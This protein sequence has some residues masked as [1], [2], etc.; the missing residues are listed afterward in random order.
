MYNNDIFD[1]F[2]GTEDMNELCK[3]AI[4]RNKIEFLNFVVN[5]ALIDS[6]D[7]YKTIIYE[8]AN[9]ELYKLLEEVGNFD[10]LDM[11]S[12]NGRLDILQYRYERYGD[13]PGKD[14][15]NTAKE[16]DHTNVIEW[17]KQIA[18]DKLYK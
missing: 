7:D 11:L 9:L 8:H 17:L 15:Y 2:D 16:N 14:E 6:F 18:I 3:L 10:D 4:E 1:S 12:K 5:N 13:S